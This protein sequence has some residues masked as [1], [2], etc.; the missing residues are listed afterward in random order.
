MFPVVN[1]VG[2]VVAVPALPIVNPAPEAMFRLPAALPVIC[3][4][5][6]D[7]VPEEIARLP[8]IATPAFSVRPLLLASVRLLSWVTLLGTL[9]PAELPPNERFDEEVVDRL[10][11]VPAIAGPFSTSVFPA[12]ASV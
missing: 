12:T 4:P 6:S 3:L 1:K 2:N 9:T 11:D 7:R 8:L 10:V 5:L